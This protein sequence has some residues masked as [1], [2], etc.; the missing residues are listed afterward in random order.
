MTAFH[1]KTQKARRVWKCWWCGE[2]IEVNEQYSSWRWADGSDVMTV[3]VHSE[4]E[5]AW[6]ALA[7]EDGY[8]YAEV[9][10]GE[11]SRGCRCQAGRCEC[12]K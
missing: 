10:F 11:F 8:G 7:V 3:R 2:R 6:N 4:C 12:E 5:Q 9:E 1:H